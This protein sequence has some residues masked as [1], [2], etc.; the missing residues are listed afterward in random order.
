VDGGA[1]TR[2]TND[3]SSEYYPCWS[4]DGKW[5]AFIDDMTDNNDA[6][7]IYMM[8]DE[9]GEIRQITSNTD[10]LE[11]GG[12]TF[13]KDGK[14]I[15]FF[16][17]G[18]I[19]SIPVEGGPPEVLVANPGYRKF[20]AHSQLA[21]SPDGSKI[22]YSARGKIWITALDGGS[23]QELLTGL[24]QGARL[25]EFDWSPDGDKIVFLCGIGG[26]AE[27]CLIS[28]FLPSN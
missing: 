3:Q 20:K 19:K 6:P 16:S 10:S 14:R 23:P 27:F 24:P 2:L 7:A 11:E 9:G 8:N 17:A 1:P 22:A 12:I 28:D 15:A 18:A 5:I 21:Y 25:S 4:P 26:E 13:S